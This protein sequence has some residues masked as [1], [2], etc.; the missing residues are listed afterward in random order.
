[1]RGRRRREGGGTNSKNKK[2]NHNYG[3]K[4]QKW[5]PWGLKIG[6]SHQG[7]SCSGI[8][9]EYTEMFREAWYHCYKITP[10]GTMPTQ[11]GRLSIR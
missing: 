10:T 6:Y 1:M 8:S 2:D 3:G 4:K 9:I 5:G 7:S 11:E